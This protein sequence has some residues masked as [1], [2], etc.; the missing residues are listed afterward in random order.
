MDAIARADTSRWRL[1]ARVFGLPA[2]I[3]SDVEARKPPGA[4]DKN[5][6]CALRR[7]SRVLTRDYFVSFRACND[8]YEYA[9]ASFRSDRRRPLCEAFAESGKMEDIP[10]DS[11]RA[12]N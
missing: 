11:A 6:D 3:L 8:I 7:A 1:C 9:L 5:R 2:K 10:C 4:L 12:Q